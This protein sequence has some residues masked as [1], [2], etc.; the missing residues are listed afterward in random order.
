M[1]EN[2]RIQER[3]DVWLDMS[4]DQRIVGRVISFRKNMYRM[5]SVI[6]YVRDLEINRFHGWLNNTIR[7]EKED[8]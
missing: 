4:G 2:R 1:R 6:R 8:G 7:I 5:D 3:L